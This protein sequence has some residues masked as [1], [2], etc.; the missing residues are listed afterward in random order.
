M[1]KWARKTFLTTQSNSFVTKAPYKSGT[2]LEQHATVSFNS[3]TNTIDDKLSPEQHQLIKIGEPVNGF[4]EVQIAITSK[5]FTKGQENLYICN[6]PHLFD[7]NKKPVNQFLAINEIY[8][9]EKQTY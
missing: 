2:K 9:N 7:R 1:L 4:K 6:S 5:P 3:H 8:F